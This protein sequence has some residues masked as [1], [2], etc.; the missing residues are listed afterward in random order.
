M[1]PI[2]PFEQEIR[3]MLRRRAS[4][5]TGADEHPEQSLVPAKPASRGSRTACWRAW[6]SRQR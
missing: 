5:I 2:D 4:D 1:T 6:L 3:D